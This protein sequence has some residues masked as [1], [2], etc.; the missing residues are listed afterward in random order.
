MQDQVQKH[1]H[2]DHADSGSAGSG[3]R[4]VMTAVHS[5]ETVA[6]DN[7]AGTPEASKLRL[8]TSNLKSSYC[9]VCNVS[10]T[11]EEVVLSLG[12]NQGWELGRREVEVKLEHRIVLGPFAAKRLADMLNSLI[13]DYERHYGELR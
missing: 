13:G 2:V 8:D 7:Q 6:A 3:R 5:S 4:A 10:S 1:H 11:K 12:I 9:N